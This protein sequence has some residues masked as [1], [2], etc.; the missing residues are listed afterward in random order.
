[1]SGARCSARPDDLYRCAN[2]VE[3]LTA[4]LRGAVAAFDRAI[5][6][7]VMQ[8]HG[9]F[10]ALSWSDPL[11]SVV[12]ALEDLGATVAQVG[13]AFEMAG[14]RLP[15]I[16][17]VVVTSDAG[18]VDGWLE[19]TSWT[20][21]HRLVAGLVGDWGNAVL[22]G[23][24]RG[25]TDAGYE[26]NGFIIG[27]DGR[28]YPLVAP[29]VTRNGQVY[30]ADEDVL[31]GRPSVLDLDGRDPGWSTIYEQIGVE[32]WRAV[33]GVM[34]RVLA[35]AGASGVGVHPGSTESD[36]EAILITPGRAPIITR[37]LSAPPVQAPNPPVYS[38]PGPPD[39]PPGVPDL[40][41]P[42]GQTSLAVGVMNI[43]PVIIDGLVGAAYADLGSHDAYDVVFQANTD[44]RVRALYRRVFVGFDDDDRDKATLDSV[45]VTGPERNDQVPIRYAPPGSG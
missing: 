41:Y 40:E 45:W 1:M 8:T 44:G 20:P 27:P 42:V 26:G 39:P 37:S 29:R 35:G 28:S 15:D 32:R 18:A 7:V 43:E 21:T 38:P 14:G 23:R 6:F 12:N 9:L 5:D 30:N 4:S 31:P 17:S 2:E 16:R 11:W 25:W 22:D 34:E 3:Q 10:A 36:V 33:P 13:A 19:V 24:C